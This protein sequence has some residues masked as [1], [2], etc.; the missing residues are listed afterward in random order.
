[1]KGAI[2]SLFFFFWRQRGRFLKREREW[3]VVQRNGN[4]NMSV[5]N[6]SDSMLTLARGPCPHNTHQNPPGSRVA[7]VR[8]RCLRRRAGCGAR[9][10]TAA[11][12][13]WDQSIFGAQ[14]IYPKN[15]V[16]L[17]EIRDAQ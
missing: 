2:P 1:M 17:A 12:N 5:G 4:G 15:P 11:V 3:R 6:V 7:K 13:N 16:T 8:S 14:K 9:I 10:M